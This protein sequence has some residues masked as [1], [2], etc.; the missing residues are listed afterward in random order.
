MRI[1]NGTPHSVDIVVG[2]VY[3]PAIRKFVGGE[4]VRSIPSD[5]ALNVRLNT[6][7]TGVLDGDI[8]LFVRTILSCDLLPEGYDIIIVSAMYAQAYVDLHGVD[9]RLYTVS[10]P[11]MTGDGKTFRGCRGLVKFC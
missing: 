9:D 3:S 8:P 6:P 10:Q 7:E 2:A 1:Y 5:G 4:V 11:V